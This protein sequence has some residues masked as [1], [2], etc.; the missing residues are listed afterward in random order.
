M[1]AQQAGRHDEAMSCFERALDQSERAVSWLGMALSQIDLKR[2][3]EAASSLRRAAT[4][5][6]K[7]GVISHLLAM[8]TGQNPG[9]APDGYVTWVFNGYA[10]GFDCHLASLGYRG[11]EMLAGLRSEEHTS[12]L[13]SLMRNSY[14]VFCLKKKKKASEK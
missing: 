7:S 14:A 1:L 2:P 6:P 13:Q 9:R 3:D 12:E 4:L 5:A 10:A 8:L 11:P